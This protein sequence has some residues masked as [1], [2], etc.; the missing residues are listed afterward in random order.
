MRMGQRLELGQLLRITED[1]CPQPAPINPAVFHRNRPSLAH[2]GE[3]W[4]VR[5]EH[6]VAN[7]IGL[8][9]DGS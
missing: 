7:S 3:G 4:T 8:D 6:C 5:L 1:D 9:D 2:C